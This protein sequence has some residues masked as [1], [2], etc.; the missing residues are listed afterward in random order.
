MRQNQLKIKAK[1]KQRRMRRPGAFRE[2]SEASQVVRVVR[3]PPANAGD[4]E[5]AGR[6]PGAGKWCPTPVLLPGASHGQRS[7]A[8]YSPRVYEESDTAE[9]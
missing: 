1:E 8:G 6:S 3:N 7:L 5:D 4:A 9:H 2:L